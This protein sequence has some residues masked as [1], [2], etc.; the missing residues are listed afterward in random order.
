MVLAHESLHNGWNDRLHIHCD[1]CHKDGLVGR[2]EAR[3]VGTALDRELYGPKAMKEGRIH[4]HAVKLEVVNRSQRM[5]DRP[6]RDD[7]YSIMIGSGRVKV[8]IAREDPQLQKV[9]FISIQ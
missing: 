9:L 5:R 8:G 2:R 7:L 6:E 3:G 1:G 4:W